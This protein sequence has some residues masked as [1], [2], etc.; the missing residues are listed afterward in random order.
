MKNPVLPRDIRDS[1]VCRRIER[2]V[3]RREIGVRGRIEQCLQRRHH[4]IHLLEIVNT[5]RRAHDA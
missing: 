5:I 3:D 2:R 4:E 1:K